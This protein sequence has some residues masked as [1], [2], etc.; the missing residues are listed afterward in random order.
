VWKLLIIEPLSQ[1]RTV[2]DFEGVLGVVGK[3]LVSQ[4]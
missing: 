2:L 3:P 4:I 1:L